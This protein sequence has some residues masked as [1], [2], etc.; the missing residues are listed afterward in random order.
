MFAAFNEL[1]IRLPFQKRERAT[2]SYRSQLSMAT[3]I[4]AGHAGNI[5]R[6]HLS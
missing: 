2:V 4:D 3:R 5:S 1:V 6:V